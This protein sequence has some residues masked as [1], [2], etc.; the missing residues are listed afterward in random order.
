MI[1]DNIISRRG[2]LPHC[3]KIMATHNKTAVAAA[4]HVIVMR[5]GYIAASGDLSCEK[6]TRCG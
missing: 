6:V 1:V 4:D 3:T 5:S 2:I